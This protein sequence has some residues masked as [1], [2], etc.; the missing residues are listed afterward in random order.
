M[1]GSNHAHAQELI[2]LSS[3]QDLSEAEQEWL[4]AHLQECAAC[5]EYAEAVGRTVSVLRSRP[6]AAD[7]SMVEAT[8][9]R[10]RARAEQLRQ[11]RERA[12]LVCLSC[13]FVG[14]SAIITTPL[15]WRACAWAGERA[16]ISDWIWQAG[17]AFFWAAPAL[18]VSALLLAHGT[19]LTS[20]GERQR[21]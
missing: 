9:W 8:R 6:L 3:G 11:Q 17:F 5:N 7:F 14:F 16:G 15:F 12:W 19:H 13:L 1:S 10:V 21:V 20:N 18:V 4:R 2:A